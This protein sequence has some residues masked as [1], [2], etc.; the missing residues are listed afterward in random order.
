MTCVLIKR[1]SDA[2]VLIIEEVVPTPTLATDPVISA[3]PN[4][5]VPVPVRVVL[6]LDSICLIS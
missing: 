6:N 4:E 5:L 1:L 3:K 2:N